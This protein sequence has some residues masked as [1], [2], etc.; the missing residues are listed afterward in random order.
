LSKCRNVFSRLYNIHEGFSEQSLSLILHALTY[1]QPRDDIC[2]SQILLFVLQY[3]TFQRARFKAVES[4]Q[5]DDNNS[6]GTN[7][8]TTI[9]VATD[10]AARGLDIPSVATVIHYDAARTVDT[11]IHRSGRTA[12]RDEHFLFCFVYNHHMV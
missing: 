2:V 4:L 8:T 1:S 9:V 10:V 12:V 7:R 11:F 6:G 3:F 5:Q